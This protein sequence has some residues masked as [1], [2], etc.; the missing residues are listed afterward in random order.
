MFRQTLNDTNFVQLP[1][2][3]QIESTLI[4]YGPGEVRLHKD[5]PAVYSNSIPVRMNSQFFM[6]KDT[7]YFCS[8]TNP[9]SEIVVAEGYQQ[10][11]PIQ[12]APQFTSLV[13]ATEILAPVPFFLTQPLNPGT[14][15]FAIPSDVSLTPYLYPY[16][17]LV[18]SSDPQT[19]SSSTHNYVIL[20][21]PSLGLM[22]S[23]LAIPLCYSSSQNGYFIPNTQ[24]PV[25][26][27]LNM[28]PSTLY[29]ECIN[30]T[31]VI[32]NDVELGLYS[33]TIQYTNHSVGGSLTPLVLYDNTSPTSIPPN[34][35]FGVTSRRV[36]KALFDVMVEGQ[37][38][39]DYTIS[40]NQMF[41]CPTTAVAQGGIITGRPL[42]SGTIPSSG[43]S[44]VFGLSCG[45]EALCISVSNPTTSTLSINNIVAYDLGA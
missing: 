24:I 14:T 8:S 42:A 41:S 44:Y 18:I 38:G 36:K 6:P 4:N 26:T 2:S 9:P 43:V 30:E 31:G 37:P 1:Y 7:V 22:M 12:L 19:L 29:C 10:F 13:P 27:A 3:K 39:L 28:M 5:L 34:Y 21:S 45:L 17:A 15:P 35:V 32:L 23:E 25:E 40:A 11:N 16:N 33:N 20:V